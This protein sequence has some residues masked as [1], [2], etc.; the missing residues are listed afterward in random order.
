[1]YEW[2]CWCVRRKG[3]CGVKKVF[4]CVLKVKFDWI[5]CSIG[6]FEGVFV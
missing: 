4:V 5:G 3:E 6:D 2:F 1:M